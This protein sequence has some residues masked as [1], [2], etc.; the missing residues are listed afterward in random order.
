MLHGK[1]RALTSGPDF[2]PGHLTLTP[3]SA[4]SFEHGMR[5]QNVAE[6]HSLAEDRP[7]K[8]RPVN[9]TTVQENDH[10]D[11]AGCLWGET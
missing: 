8:D 6:H 5:C 9:D 2:T 4:S 7:I 10:E 11:A 3:I 1:T